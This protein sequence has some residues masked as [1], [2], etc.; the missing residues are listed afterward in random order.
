MTETYQNENGDILNF[1]THSDPVLQ[2][3]KFGT[4]M[5]HITLHAD[6]PHMR[7]TRNPRALYRFVN[8]GLAGFSPP[9]SM[10]LKAF[11]RQVKGKI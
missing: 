8:N 2:H 7:A 3:K 9:P 1:S 5:A 11:L 6:G 4:E 10:K